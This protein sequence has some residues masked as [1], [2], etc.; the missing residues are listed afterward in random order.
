[1]K[2]YLGKKLVCQ[3]GVA[4]DPWSKAWGWM[5]HTP[6]KDEGLLFVL[7]F[8]TKPQMWMLLCTSRINMAFLDKDFRVIDFQQAVPLTL[9]PAT[10]RLYIP[11]KICSYV[12]ELHPDRKLKIGDKLKVAF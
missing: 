1:M 2:A 9:D 7:M 4:R 3:G 10:W 8:E 12:L 11:K 6:K 5:L